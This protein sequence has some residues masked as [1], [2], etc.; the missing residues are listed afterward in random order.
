MHPELPHPHTL[1]ICP[2]QITPEMVSDVCLGS[3]KEKET[4]N[5]VFATTPCGAVPSDSQLW[6]FWQLDNETYALQNKASS[7]CFDMGASASIIGRAPVVSGSTLTH[8]P[9]R[10]HPGAAHVCS[11]HTCPHSWSCCAGKVWK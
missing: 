8:L 3:I 9:C 7:L 10:H 11:F 1:C 5:T 4:G 2:V 6:T